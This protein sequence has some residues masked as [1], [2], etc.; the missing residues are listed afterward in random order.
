M[1]EDPTLDPPGSGFPTG[2]ADG[3]ASGTPTIEELARE[4]AQL[5]E[6]LAKATAEAAEY[7]RATYDIL[8]KLVPYVPPADEEMHELIHGPRGRS[9]LEIID[10]LEREPNK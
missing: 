2:P 5:R 4:N 10:E 9:I 1:S 7:R 3:A 6:Q 8:K